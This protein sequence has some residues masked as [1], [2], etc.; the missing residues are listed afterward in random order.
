MKTEDQIKAKIKKMAWERDIYQELANKR[1]HFPGDRPS[2]AQMN[3]ELLEDQ[4]SILRW[5]LDDTQG[6]TVAT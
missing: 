6:E 3:A 5:V 1:C 4:I 2:G